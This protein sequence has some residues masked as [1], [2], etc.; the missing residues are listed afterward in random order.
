MIFVDNTQ[1]YSEIEA[2][3]N[4]VKADP[5]NLGLQVETMVQIFDTALDNLSSIENLAGVSLP[6]FIGMTMANLQ[7]LAQVLQVNEIDLP[8]IAKLAIFQNLELGQK[9]A[10]VLGD[11]SREERA[12]NADVVSDRPSTVTGSTGTIAD[13]VAS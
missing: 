3:C 11:M 12:K 13:P 7:A 8:A 1:T 6:I 5:E 2:L 10:D 9:M 4:S